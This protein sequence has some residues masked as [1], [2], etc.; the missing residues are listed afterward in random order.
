MQIYR[1]N[2]N[3]DDLAS[4]QNFS[5]AMYSCQLHILTL[6]SLYSSQA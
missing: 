2:K 4:Q 5:E 1:K 3:I 6:P